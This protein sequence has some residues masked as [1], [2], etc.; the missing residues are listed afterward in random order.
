MMTL[1]LWLSNIQKNGRWKIMNSHTE[2]IAVIQI[3]THCRRTFFSI[4]KRCFSFF[5]AW[6]EHFYRFDRLPIDSF[7]LYKHK[8]KAAQHCQFFCDKQAPAFNRESLR[9]LTKVW[10]EGEPWNLYQKLFQPSLVS[11]GP[12]ISSRR[13]PWVSLE[14]GNRTWR[15]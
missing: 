5:Q 12:H 14:L 11:T 13:P 6:F 7:N 2:I 8:E 9:V 10:F 3:I 15:E 1:W 4:Y